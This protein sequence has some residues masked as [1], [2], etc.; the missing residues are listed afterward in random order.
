MTNKEISSRPIL[1]LGKSI[2]DNNENNISEDQPTQ[3][4][5][6]TEKSKSASAHISNTDNKS[7]IIIKTNPVVNTKAELKAELKP[8]PKP[9][10]DFNAIYAELHSK[11][12]EIINM[13]KP[14]LLAIAIRGEMLK[15]V[16]VPNA[17]LNKWIRWYFRKSNYY[18]LH[19]IKAM[20][21]NLDGSEAGAVT[22]KDQ[23]KRDKQMEK[24]NMV[25]S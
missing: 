8:T 9:E 7:S 25:S 20:R 5:K 24:K 2:T 10:H 12:P 3:S 22:E 21:Y 18:S 6:E 19:Q 17:I 11:F 1:T 23:A 16:S 14:V 4:G 15:E 13:D